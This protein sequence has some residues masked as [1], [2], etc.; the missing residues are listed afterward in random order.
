MMGVIDGIAL[1][2]TKYDRLIGDGRS[3][4][5]INVTNKCLIYGY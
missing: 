5:R 4:R 2:V 3:Y 1:S